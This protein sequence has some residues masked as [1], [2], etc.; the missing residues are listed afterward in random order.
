MD[1]I[2]KQ[3]TD[4]LYGEDIPVVDTAQ[5]V[6]DALVETIFGLYLAGMHERHGMTMPIE[7]KEAV[8]RLVA[9]DHRRRAR[10]IAGL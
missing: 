3:I 1:P 9:E 10:Q 2:V 7:S 5:A 4:K 6:E 8:S